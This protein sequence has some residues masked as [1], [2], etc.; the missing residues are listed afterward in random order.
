M[1]FTKLKLRNS[2]SSDNLCMPDKEHENTDCS[3]VVISYLQIIVRR[4]SCFIFTVMS[5]FAQLNIAST[6]FFMFNCPAT[7]QILSIQH[8][9]M[10]KFVLLLIKH[11]ACSMDYAK[12][13]LKISSLKI[14][15]FNFLIETEAGIWRK[16]R[17]E[18]IHTEKVLSRKL[19]QPSAFWSDSISI[20]ATWEML[21][22][23]EMGRVC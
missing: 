10:F 22:K 21:L 4:G 12:T 3:P 16:T 15:L 20:S 18:N 1:L 2:R 13:P 14:C 23:T 6:L 7:G 9:E 8:K 5:S 17:R 11:Q 19:C